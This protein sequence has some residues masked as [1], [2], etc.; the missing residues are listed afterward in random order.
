MVHVDDGARDDVP[1][2]VA[3]V[4]KQLKPSPEI[5]HKLTVEAGPDGI[6]ANRPA[7]IDPLNSWLYDL[8]L[9]ERVASALGA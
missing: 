7:S 3:D 1:R 2:P 8:W 5:W 9:C 6:T 4:L